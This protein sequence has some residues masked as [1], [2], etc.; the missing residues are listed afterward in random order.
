M[1]KLIIRAFPALLLL[2]V[3]FAPA[4]AGTDQLAARNNLQNKKVSAR[5]VR[6]AASTISF[7]QLSEWESA[8]LSGNA[9]ALSALYSTTPPAVT[10]IGKNESYDPA[11]EPNFWAAAKSGGLASLKTRIA[12]V[13]SPQP[14]V[15]R[16]MF[17]LEASMHPATAPQ[18]VFAAIA[19]YWL[20]GKGKWE[21]V[22]TQRTP[23][24]RLPQPAVLLLPEPKG[25]DPGPDPIYPNAAEA[26]ADIA[27][28][29]AAAARDRKRVLLDFGGNWCSDCRVLD[30][31]F[32]YPEVARLLA[33]NFEVVHVNIG[34]YDQNL[35]LAD[36]YQIPLKRGVPELAVLDAHGNLLV[37]QKNADFENTS[38]IG[39]QDVEAFLERWKPPR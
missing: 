13:D 36:K 39:L 29:L 35:D 26:K 37:S 31:T 5:N 23:L 21:I 17:E 16:V 28:A 22:A 12:T 2:F 15:H 7:P 30:A 32:H 6:A 19:Q 1:S 33:P 4:I 20:E 38:K 3:G 8:V 10:V 24:E 11:F 18:K 14:G 25:D 34:E 27:A 9:T